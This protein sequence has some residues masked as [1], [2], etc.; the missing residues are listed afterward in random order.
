MGVDYGREDAARALDGNAAAGLLTELFAFDVTTAR[1][2]CDGCGT[3]NKIATARVYAG[4]VLKQAG[5]P[6]SRA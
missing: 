1:L 5:C 6:P 2:T 3:A 4:P